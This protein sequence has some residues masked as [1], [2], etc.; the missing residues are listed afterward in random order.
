IIKDKCTG[1]G[2]FNQYFKGYQFGNLSGGNFTTLKRAIIRYG[3]VSVT[4]YFLKPNPD[5]TDSLLPGYDLIGGWYNFVIGWNSTDF[6]TL[7]RQPTYEKYPGTEQDDYTK[8]ISQD[9]TKGRASLTY[10][11]T[12][13]GKEVTYDQLYF[14][15]IEVFGNS[16]SV[17]RAALGLFAAVLILPAL[18]L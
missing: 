18:L 5:N 1:T 4:Y 11:T 16:V 9:W 10:T 12:E 14:S 8:P 3:P 7:S 17:V 15:S 6:I 13:D 2:S